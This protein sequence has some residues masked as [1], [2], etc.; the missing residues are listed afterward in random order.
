[1]KHTGNQFKYSELRDKELIKIFHKCIM[2]SESDN[3]SKILIQTVNSPAS[4]FWVSE[5]RAAIILSKMFNGDKLDNMTDTKQ[6]MYQE[7][8]RRAVIRKQKYPYKSIYE[9]AIDVTGQP[10]PKFYLTPK[11]AK[12]IICKIKKKWRNSK[13]NSLMI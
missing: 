3:L 11:S 10:A 9:I 8:F 7:L 4:R 13:K 12:T 1:M 5:E 2:E 6:E